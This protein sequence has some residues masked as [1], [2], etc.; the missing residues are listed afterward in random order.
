MGKTSESALV[1]SK[2]V[3][4]LKDAEVKKLQDEM[5]VP[6]SY[7]QETERMMMQPEISSKFEEL[8]HLEQLIASEEE[9]K[10]DRLKR[11]E[12]AKAEV[13][14]ITRELKH[15]ASESSVDAEIAK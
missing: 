12:S 3:D 15:C 6:E 7:I 14:K 1:K 13:E 4:K 2:E 5:R 10:S 11:L 9:E 8:A